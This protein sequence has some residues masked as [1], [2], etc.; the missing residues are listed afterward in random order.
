LTTPDHKPRWLWHWNLDDEAVGEAPDDPALDILSQ[1]GFNPG[2]T[3]AQWSPP[4][5]A[6]VKLADLLGSDLG[7][8]RHYFAYFLDD[9]PAAPAGVY[10]FFARLT[11]PGYETSEPFLVALNLNVFDEQQQLKGAL[12]INLAA[13]LA[14]DF[15]IDGA[16]DGNDVLVWQR[17]LGA[18]GTYPAAD[19][20]LNGTVDAADLVLWKEQFGRIVEL[21]APTVAAVPEPTFRAL[22][23]AIGA[24]LA[25]CRRQRSIVG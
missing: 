7:E 8:H 18:T 16:V 11:A 3:L 22:L 21:P 12:A 20:S 25:A 17:D 1:R 5:N 14:G 19:G 10:G 24:M 2:A 9:S 15:D 6:T 13:G 4:A 23:A